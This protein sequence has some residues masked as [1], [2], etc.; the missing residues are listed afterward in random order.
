MERRHFLSVLTTAIAVIAL[1]GL[2]PGVIADTP[3]NMDK[4]EKT[5]SKNLLRL[6]PELIV[7]SV[8]PLNAI[9]GL[10]EVHVRDSIFYT[11][12]KG[13]HL[14]SGHIIETDTHRDITQL[15]I[16]DINRVDWKTLPLKNAIVSGDAKGIPVAIFTDPDCPFC[17]QLEQE[18]LK[19][20]GVKFYTFLFPLESLHKHAR[21][22][23]EAIWCAMDQ[24]KALQDVMLHDKQAGDIKGTICKS[25]VS[26]NIALGKK[27][28]I[29]GTPTLIAGDGRKHAGGFAAE[30][31][32]QWASQ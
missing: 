8:R 14:I 24:H 26:D 16:E 18:L 20:K 15:R 22:K 27:L 6:S 31:L 29:T 23:A 12:A 5:I 1:L 2:S 3:Q 21:A 4:I 25:P 19:V 7:K 9:P 13:K 11:D 32:Q 17:R 28:G 10:Y 30:Q